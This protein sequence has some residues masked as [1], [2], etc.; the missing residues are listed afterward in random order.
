MSNPRLRILHLEDNPF[1]SEFVQMALDLGGINHQTFYAMTKTEFTTA[2]NRGGFDVILS[3]SNLPGF[4][5][6]AAL[7][8]ARDKYPEVPFVFVTGHA[9]KEKVAS[10]KEAGAKEVIAKSDLKSLAIALVAALTTRAA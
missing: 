3:D 2:L 10:L 6:E 5:G 9:P 1:D 8:M 7:G 4:D